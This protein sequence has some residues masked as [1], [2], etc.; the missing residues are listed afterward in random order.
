MSTHASENVFPYLHSSNENEEKCLIFTSWMVE[1]LSEAV[2][3]DRGASVRGWGF[4]FLPFKW[5]LKKLRPEPRLDLEKVMIECS[6]TGLGN[7]LPF[8]QLFKACGLNWWAIFRGGVIFHFLVKTAFVIFGQLSYRHWVTFYS[9]LL[10]TLSSK[11]EKQTKL[12][13]IPVRPELWQNFTTLTIFKGSVPIGQ[14]FEPSCYWANFHWWRY[15][16]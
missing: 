3:A 6:V 9:K 11:T 16:A 7:W 15:M 2:V 8:G 1:A 4:P 5:P 10:V 14:N 12:R 13:K